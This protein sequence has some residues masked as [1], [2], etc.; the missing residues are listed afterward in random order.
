MTDWHEY[1][2]YCIGRLGGPEG[3]GA[4]HSLIEADPAVVPVLISAFRSEQDAGIRAALVEIIWQHRLP[5]TAGFLVEALADPVPEVWK[6]ALD[7]LVT[8]GPSAVPIL[9]SALDRIQRTT[10]ME[11]TRA[12][13]IEEALDQMKELGK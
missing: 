1:A 9:Q 7:G 2:R 13:W 10:V 3:E 11:R 12:E 8:L 6:S 5:E 4:C